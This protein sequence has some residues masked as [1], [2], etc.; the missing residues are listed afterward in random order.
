MKDILNIFQKRLVFGLDDY[1]IE[2]GTSHKCIVQNA[3][4][5]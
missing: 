1:N 5:L 4:G 2:N 3:K